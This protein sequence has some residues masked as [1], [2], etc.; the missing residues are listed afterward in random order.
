MRNASRI[1]YNVMPG[2]PLLR[3]YTLDKQ[4]EWFEE[5]LQRWIFQ[6]AKLLLDIGD[7]NNDYAVLAILNA[8]PEMLAK[9]QGYEQTYQNEVFTGKRPGQSAYL[10]RKGIEY[11]FPQRG[12]NVF[13]DDEMI[14]D[15]IYGKLRC[16]LAHFAFVGEK[17][18][19]TRDSGNFDSIIIDAVHISHL[20][21]WTYS[22]PACLL[23]I[24]VTVWYDQIQMRVGDY[25]SDLRNQSNRDLRSKFSDRVTRSDAPR[26]GAP[27][28]C[29]CGP[30]RFCTNCAD[31]KFPATH[32]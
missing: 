15:L 6:P 23:S 22:P 14:D 29:V 1:P 32:L 11:L 28:G 21:R 17:I 5:S 4:I 30:N 2:S 12:D 18:L 7:A 3:T 10:Y 8:V 26:K 13:E 24:D 31:S 9:C 27:T 25:I 19:L 16:G 20:P